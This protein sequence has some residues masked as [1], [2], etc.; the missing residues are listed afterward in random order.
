M[1]LDDVGEQIRSRLG[2]SCGLVLQREA[3]IAIE[4]VGVPPSPISF[5][6]YASVLGELGLG[7]G[8]GDSFVGD[9]GLSGFVDGAASAEHS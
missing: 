1:P 8:L 2:V 7:E 6:D 9:E 4:D 5:I 3:P